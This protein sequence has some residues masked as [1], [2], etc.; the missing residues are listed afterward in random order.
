MASSVT[1]NQKTDQHATDN[2]AIDNHATEEYEKDFT[3]KTANRRISRPTVIAALIVIVLAGAGLAGYFIYQGTF[4]YQTNNAKVDTVIHQ[5]TAN[6]TGQLLRLYVTQGEAVA[7]GQVLAQV[8]KGPLIRSP[9][10]G[11][12]T[13][14][15][16]QDG[17]YVT[18]TDVILVVAKTADMYI[19]ANVEETNILKIQVGQ[20]VSVYL[21]AYGRNFD[22]YVA[23]VA[24]VTSTKL[25][26]AVTSF[27]TSGTYT[28]VTQL[29]PVKIKLADNVDLTNIIGTNATV[30][31]RIK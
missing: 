17:D 4:Y 1:T 31:I 20:R 28:K 23:E 10:D 22:G 27:T 24:M 18:A 13:N 14:I 29:I 9:I 30:K 26:G 6:A 16:P 3:P 15:M 21:D 5:L 8:Q 2:H 12:V 19:T 7:A 25:S 11:T